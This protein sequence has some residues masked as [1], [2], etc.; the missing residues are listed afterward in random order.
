VHIS[1]CFAILLDAAKYSQ[2]KCYHNFVMDS[3]TKEITPDFP[4]FPSFNVG[5]VDVYEPVRNYSDSYSLKCF[6]I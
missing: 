5:S 6:F 3:N 4:P 1:Y 2:N